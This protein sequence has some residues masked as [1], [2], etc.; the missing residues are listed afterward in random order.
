M[1]Q[2]HIIY[3]PGIQDDRLRGQSL[4]TSLWRLYGVRGHCHEMPWFGPE[5]FEPKMQKL[6][7][8]ID[9]YRAQGHCVSLIGASAGASA[10]INAYVQRREDISALIYICAKINAPETVSDRTYSANPAFKTSMYKLQDNLKELTSED[11]AKMHS[12]YSPADQVVPYEA[13]VIPGVAESR[14]PALRH[15]EAIIY[16]LSLGARRMLS[17]LS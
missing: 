7:G 1:G 4:L 5:P 13:T 11:K 14:L 8:R 12:F 10:V 15:G 3:V 6:L 17:H 16:S 2:H 9:S